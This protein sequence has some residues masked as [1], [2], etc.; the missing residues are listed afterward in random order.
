M[1]QPFSI[2]EGEWE[3]FEVCPFVWPFAFL[4]FAWNAYF[5]NGFIKHSGIIHKA[6]HTPAKYPTSELHSQIGVC[7]TFPWGETG[8]ELQVLSL[9]MQI[10]VPLVNVAPN[11]NN[12]RT[13]EILP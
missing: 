1:A 4:I 5:L 3:L 2:E 7:V 11:Q 9:F 8:C 13:T 10:L 6:L 12:A